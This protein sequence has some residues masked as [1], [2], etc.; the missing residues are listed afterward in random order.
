MSNQKS[1]VLCILTRSTCGEN[2]EVIQSLVRELWQI[3][4]NFRPPWWQSQE[5]DRHRSDRSI[6]PGVAKRAKFIICTELRPKIHKI[7]LSTPPPKK[8]PKT[9][10]TPPHACTHTH[11]RSYVYRVHN[12]DSPHFLTQTRTCVSPRLCTFI[13]GG[14][15]DRRCF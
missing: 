12:E 1:R 15:L 2:L 9:A 3:V 11:H 14:V 10:N 8:K 7:P 4:V 6:T 13:C 5:S